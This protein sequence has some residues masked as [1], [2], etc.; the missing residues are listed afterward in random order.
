MII[1]NEILYQLHT[2]F[3]SSIIHIIHIVG[4]CGWYYL[5]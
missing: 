4:V 3:A 5:T 1:N 2:I